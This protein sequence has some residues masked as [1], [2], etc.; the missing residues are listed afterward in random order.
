[1]WLKKRAIGVHSAQPGVSSGHRVAAWTWDWAGKSSVLGIALEQWCRSQLWEMALG[2]VCKADV[3][4][5]H[6]QEVLVL[7][8]EVREYISRDGGLAQT[9]CQAQKMPCWSY[10]CVQA[11]CS[12][13]MLGQAFGGKKRDLIA[14][15]GEFSKPNFPCCDF[16][17]VPVSWRLEKWAHEMSW[18]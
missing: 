10:V 9:V 4:G 14:G 18:Q 12:E 6:F 11:V 5:S 1:M 2:T 16:W 7:F 8:P 3:L 15:I 17:Q 13:L